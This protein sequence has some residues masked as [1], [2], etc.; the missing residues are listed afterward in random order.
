MFH[1]FPWIWSDVSLCTRSLAAINA[2]GDWMWH[3]CPV[4]VFANAISVLQTVVTTQTETFVQTDLTYSEHKFSVAS[5]D[6]VII[7]SN[8][9]AVDRHCPVDIWR[10]LWTICV[11]SSLLKPHQAGFRV[12]VRVFCLH[13]R[14]NSDRFPKI[15][16]M[17]FGHQASRARIK[18][19]KMWR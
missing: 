10:L 7:R 11:F 14:E 9:P 3:S 16:F 12:P 4:R 2:K 17:C 15:G 5:L 18:P 13:N 19:T 6:V 1:R 8:V